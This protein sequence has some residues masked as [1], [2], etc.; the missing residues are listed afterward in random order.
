[1]PKKKCDCV[2]YV[3]CSHKS[4]SFAR[5][6]RGIFVITFR[7]EF[8]LK[9]KNNI[10]KKYQSAKQAPPA[11]NCFTASSP[12]FVLPNAHVHT[13]PLHILHDASQQL[14]GEQKMDF[15][16]PFPLRV[17]LLN[18]LSF[19]PAEHTIPVAPKEDIV[20][21]P[22]S[23]LLAKLLSADRAGSVQFSNPSTLAGGCVSPPE[24]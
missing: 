11:P 22:F 12:D 23:C 7:R 2:R 14:S 4:T 9:V 21:I 5:S 24:R 15:F 6:L 8:T 16:L 18:K 3:I 17:D 1:M 19:S 13:I 20:Y 10:C